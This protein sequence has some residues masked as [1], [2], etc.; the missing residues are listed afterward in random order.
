MHKLQSKKLCPASN[1]R[2]TLAKVFAIFNNRGLYASPS[3]QPINE[4]MGKGG[5]REKRERERKEE[6]GEKRK[7]GKEK[8]LQEFAAVGAAACKCINIDDDRRT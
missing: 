2:A 3:R 7:R 4:G 8:E 5:R 1:V 6:R